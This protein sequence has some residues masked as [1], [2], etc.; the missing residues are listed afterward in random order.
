MQALD[1]NPSP[2]LFIT[3]VAELLP[4]TE[5]LKALLQRRRELE[6]QQQQEE[7]ERLQDQR[8][9]S[10]AL[11]QHDEY[12]RRSQLQRR[13]L[14]QQQQQLTK[15][16]EGRSL[17]DPNFSSLLRLGRSP[18]VRTSS[19]SSSSGSSSSSSSSS[20]GGPFVPRF[21]SLGSLGLNPLQIRLLLREG[22]ADNPDVEELD[23]SRVGLTDDEGPA[24]FQSLSRMQSLRAVS[25][26][27]NYLGRASAAALAKWIEAGG[28]LLLES[29]RKNT[30]LQCLDISDNHISW[31]LKEAKAVR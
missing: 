2:P 22:L 4:Q 3:P 30:S 6:L 11:Q 27:A 14:Q 15:E 5:A 13:L 28:D 19:S 8:L 23:L 7:G 26:E 24:I 17:Q 21:L 12:V 25:V 18:R 31:R 16:E 1:S 29:L 9:Q 10:L 20:E